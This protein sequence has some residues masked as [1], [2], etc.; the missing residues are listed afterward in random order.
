MNNSHKLSNLLE[1][2]P[3]SDLLRLFGIE[4]SDEPVRLKAKVL[5]EP[6]LRFQNSQARVTDGKWDL[7]DVQF[8][9]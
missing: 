4:R 2:N 6:Q 5:P 9:S 8:N 1:S 7:R 3:Q